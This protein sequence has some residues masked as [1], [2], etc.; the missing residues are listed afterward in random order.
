[1]TA[2]N[3]RIDQAKKAFTGWKLPDLIDHC[4]WMSEREGCNDRRNRFCCIGCGRI[5]LEEFGGTGEVVS[6]INVANA[7]VFHGN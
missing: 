2:S 7:L 3:G 4:H 1:M 6:G 5:G